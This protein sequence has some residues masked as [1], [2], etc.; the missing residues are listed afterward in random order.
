MIPRSALKKS[1]LVLATA[2]VAENIAAVHAGDV[3]ARSRFP[4]E[5]FAALREARLLSAAVP[6][7]FGGAG[8]GMLPCSS[9]IARP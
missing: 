5:T 4:E 1:P 8:A 3:D 6:A 2:A 9:E 7:A